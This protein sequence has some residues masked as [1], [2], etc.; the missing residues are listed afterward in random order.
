MEHSWLEGLSASEVGN[1]I[2]ERRAHA[3]AEHAQRDRWVAIVE[4]ALPPWLCRPHELGH[5]AAKEGTESSLSAANDSRVR[6]TGG[7]ATPTP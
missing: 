3:R 6:T 2:A 1:E 5:S 7:L 4:A